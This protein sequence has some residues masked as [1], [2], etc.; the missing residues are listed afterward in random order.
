[1][2]EVLIVSRTK[3]QSDKVCVGGLSMSNK[4]SLR[5]LTENGY[6]QNSNSPFEVGQIWELDW[7]CRDLVRP[8]HTEDVCVRHAK[9]KRKQENLKKY[10]LDNCVIWH[11][12]KELFEGALEYTAR[13]KGYIS[14]ENIPKMST[15]FWMLEEDSDLIEE[16]DKYY[17]CCNNIKLKYVGFADKIQMIR[18]GF[19]IRLS[20]ARW[21][22]D[23]NAGEKRCYLQL[24]G[25]YD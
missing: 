9:Y 11:S 5:L 21:W 17:Y 7:S 15:G 12:S 6:N 14:E 1:M 10:L 18:K 25:W 2:G 22:F 19:L 24:S 20:L 3:M 23:P 16:F 13:K 8:P 4:K